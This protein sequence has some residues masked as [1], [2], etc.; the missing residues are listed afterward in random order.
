MEDGAERFQ[1]SRDNCT[2]HGRT[3]ILVNLPPLGLPEQDLQRANQ[4]NI[5]EVG[6]QNH[7]VLT[8]KEQRVI[9]GKEGRFSL[10]MRLLVL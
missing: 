8:E 10:K 4:F 7:P 2:G 9:R 1:R 6:N 5:G 3:D